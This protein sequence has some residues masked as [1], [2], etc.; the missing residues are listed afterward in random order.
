MTG[1]VPIYNFDIIQGVLSK[2]DDWRIS[3]IFILKKK[4]HFS[5][6]VRPENKILSL[7]NLNEITLARTKL[8][9]MKMAGT[10]WKKKFS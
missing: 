6:F 10:P 4:P 3:L 9:C 7:Q 8:L 1:G 2:S 5:G